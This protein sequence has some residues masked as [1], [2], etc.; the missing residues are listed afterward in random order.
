MLPPLNFRIPSS[1]LLIS[2]AIVAL[3]F[4]L[5]IAA[6]E[7]KP[8]HFDEG[9]NGWFVDQITRDGFYHY[10]PSNFHGP[11][12]F[13]LLWL[14]Q[15]LLGRDLWTLRLPTV[16][17]STACVAL[18]LAFGAH[19]RPRTCQIAALAMAISPGMIFYGRDAIHESA[20]LFFLMLTVWGGAGLRRF[21]GRRH[22]WAAALGI[23]GMVLT[24]ETYVIHFAVL[25]L[26]LPSLWIVEAFSRAAKV[27]KRPTLNAQRSTLNEAAVGFRRW[28]LDVGRWTFS[29]PRHWSADDLKAALFASA[30]LL[31]F[32]YTGGF[33]DWPDWHAAPGTRGSLAGLWETFQL[34]AR[35]GTGGE[36][37]HEKPWSYFLDLLTRYEW[38]AALGLLATPVLLVARTDRFLRFLAISGAGALAAYS[39]ISYKTPWC[40]LPVMWPFLFVFAHAVER[41]FATVDRWVAVALA[42]LLCGGSLALALRLN[43][44]AF[45]DENEP[46]VY[47]QTLPDI[48]KLLGPLRTLT[49]RDPNAFHLRG[50]IL[51]PISD[52]HPLPWALGD[53]TKVDFLDAQHPPAEMDADF[54]LVEDAIV[55]DV[56]E[57][58]HEHYFKESLNLRGAS[59]LAL[60]LYLR[61]TTFAEF[62]PGRAP[63]FPPA[64]PSDI[65]S[66]I[67]VIEP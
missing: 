30:L 40:L 16:L 9:V 24:K 48:D 56:E 25:G 4:A 34:W 61:D 41:G 58:L 2:C 7:I 43:F 49:A 60:T 54:L 65:G 19:L 20:L 52:S 50:H 47:V 15:T 38:P 42:V 39:L 17:I 10:D 33:L 23:T 27:G 45:T 28:T 32:F 37:G 35:T 51:L 18:A 6:L 31:V 13:Y 8:A 26:A 46:Y 62:F 59:G 36:S 5:R 63:D 14:S 29:G 67:P 57:R 53:F 55:A 1:R 66:L 12:H 3:A 22:L 44:R 21:G 64:E 11:L